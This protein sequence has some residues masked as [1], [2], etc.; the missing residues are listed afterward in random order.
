MAKLLYSVDVALKN[1]GEEK[2]LKDKAAHELARHYANAIDEISAGGCLDAAQ[3]LKDL[4]PQFQKLLGSLGLT[5][6]ARGELK[7]KPAEPVR[8]SKI[9]ELEEKRRQRAPAAG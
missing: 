9:D 7:T 1:L 3:A 4:G 8:K 5:P 2:S 6:E